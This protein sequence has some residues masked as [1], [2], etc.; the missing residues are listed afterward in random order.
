MILRMVAVGEE[1]GNVEDML[2]RVADRY[3]NDLKKSIKR[4]LALFEPLIIV[5]LGLGVGL[6]VL[7]MF[8]AIMDMQHAV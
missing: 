3:E 6:I 8:M 1:T 4:L 2:D 5:F 7:L